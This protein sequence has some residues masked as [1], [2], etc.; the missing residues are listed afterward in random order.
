MKTKTFWTRNYS[1]DN[2]KCCNGKIDIIVIHST[3]SKVQFCSWCGEQCRYIKDI[4]EDTFEVT[5]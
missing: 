3:D 2:E 5:K 4:S 1:C